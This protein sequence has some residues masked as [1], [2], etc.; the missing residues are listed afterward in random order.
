MFYFLD[1]SD[2][3]LHIDLGRT[4][5]SD[6][7]LCDVLCFPLCHN[8]RLCRLLVLLLVLLHSLITW[9]G[10]CPPGLP[11][12][13]YLFFF[14]NK[15]SSQRDNFRVLHILFSRKPFTQ[16][17]DGSYLNQ[18]LHWW[19]QNGDFLILAFLLH[20]LTNNLLQRRAFCTPQWYMYI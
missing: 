17:F 4:F 11:L 2:S 6:Y 12:Q 14:V 3:F 7:Y 16:W 8:R 13:S 1:F 10:W 18:L 15:S 9:W 20:W 5:R 19:L